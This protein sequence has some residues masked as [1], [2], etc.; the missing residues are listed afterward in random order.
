ML[1]KD[2]YQI[3][4]FKKSRRKVY[5]MVSSWENEGTSPPHFRH[6]KDRTMTGISQ[7]KFIKVISSLT[8]LI[9]FYDE[10]AGSVDERRVKDVA[11]LKQDFQ[12]CL[13]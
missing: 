10:M 6:M 3:S 8:N 2:K 1:G 5:S 13:L 4:I 9:A 7:Q 12:H 11:Y